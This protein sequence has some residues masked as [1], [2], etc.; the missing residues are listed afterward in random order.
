MKIRLIRFFVWGILFATKLRKAENKVF[1]KRKRS[2]EDAK[3]KKLI[4]LFSNLLVAKVMPL[5]P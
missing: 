3:E 2:L 1:F 5:N 4:H